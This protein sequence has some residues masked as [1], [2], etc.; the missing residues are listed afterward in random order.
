MTVTDTTTSTSHQY[1]NA[2]GTAFA[3]VQD[4]RTFPCGTP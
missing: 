4:F 2:D 3:P 1:V